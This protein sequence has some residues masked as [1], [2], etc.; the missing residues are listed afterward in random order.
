[1]IK[2]N[3]YIVNKNKSI[4]NKQIIDYINYQR[5]GFLS[6]LSPFKLWFKD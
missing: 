6:K 1:M 2:A 3:K 4:R 5:F